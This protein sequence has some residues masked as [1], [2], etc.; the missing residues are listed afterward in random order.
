M[1]KLFILSV[2]IYSTQAFSQNYQLKKELFQLS[3]V[4]N[5]KTVATSQLKIDSGQVGNH[6]FVNKTVLVDGKVIATYDSCRLYIN[7]DSYK[8]RT[9]AFSLYNKVKNKSSGERIA[10]LFQESKDNVVVTITDNIPKATNDTLNSWM[11]Y[12][13]LKDFEKSQQGVS[14]TA[15][16]A[17][18][19]VGSLVFSL[20]Y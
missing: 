19:F 12:M 18:A 9:P 10:T 16:A 11:L 2:L 5:D 20:L 13:Q 17:G 15:V 7:E 1:K 4:L 14:W 6:V 8:F 3:F